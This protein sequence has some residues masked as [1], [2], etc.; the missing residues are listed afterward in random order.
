VNSRF[1]STAFLQFNGSQ[2]V[3][4]SVHLANA[5]LL[6]LSSLSAPEAA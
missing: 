6:R 3:P 2:I 1:N 5:M 4:T